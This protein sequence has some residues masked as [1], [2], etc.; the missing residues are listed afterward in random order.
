[1]RMF[2]E[3]GTI[4]ITNLNDINNPI[5]EYII[6]G[7]DDAIGGDLLLYQ[8][9]LGNDVLPLLPETLGDYQVHIWVGDSMEGEG[10]YL[11]YIVVRT[12]LITE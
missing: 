3:T 11:G 8:D 5:S 7:Y 4:R 6:Y 10:L 9:R 2:K 12:G 1:L